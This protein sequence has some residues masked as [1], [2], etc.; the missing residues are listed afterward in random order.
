MSAAFPAS[1]RD[2]VATDLDGTLF[3]RHWADENAI[4]GTWREITS[5]DGSKQ[6]EP[7]SW[8]RPETHRLLLALAKT[9]SIVPVTARDVASFSRVD[10]PGLRL[11][12]PAILAN[13]A[14]VLG[15]DGAPDQRWVARVSEVLVPWRQNLE[16]LCEILIQRSG[17]IARPRLVAGPAEL[18]AYLVAKAPDGWWVGAEG[19]ALRK[20]IAAQATAECSVVVMG[21][22]LQVLPLGLGKAAALRFIQQH[23][24]NGQAPLLCLGDQLPDLEFMRMGGQLATPAGS[25]LAE[26]WAS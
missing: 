5:Q 7:S 17:H 1:T 4:P 26:I 10:V 12:A 15:L 23:Y 24:F 6:R 21:N 3:S 13:G 20:V 11:R 16:R 25:P 8:V 14:I 18:P 22:E 19:T 2:W 9:M